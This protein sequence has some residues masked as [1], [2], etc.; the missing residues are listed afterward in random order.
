MKELPIR[1]LGK[2]KLIKEEN[3]K[4]FAK[5]PEEKEL[6]VLLKGKHNK[7]I[8][9]YKRKLPNSFKKQEFEK[10][11][12]FLKENFN[13]VSTLRVVGDY[14]YIGDL[15]SKYDKLV[16]FKKNGKINSE[17]FKLPNW[18]EITDKLFSEVLELA[19]RGLFPVDFSFG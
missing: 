14:L 18:K 19:N 13:T 10:I 4:K 7:K 11:I 16:D 12:S 2:W 6:K 15:R 5:E 8:S 1:T 17:I 9:L 3:I